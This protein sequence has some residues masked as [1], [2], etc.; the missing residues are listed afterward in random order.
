VNELVEHLR[1]A[2]ASDSPWQRE[3]PP[4]HRSE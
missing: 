3:S 2:F 4:M 1:S